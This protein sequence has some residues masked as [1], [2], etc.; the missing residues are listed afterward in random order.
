[1]DR[2][3]FHDVPVFLINLA[4]GGNSQAGHGTQEELHT[5]HGSRVQACPGQFCGPGS[6]RQRL[7][8]CR[9]D[10]QTVGQQPVSSQ[11]V[12]ELAQVEAT[13]TSN[14]HLEDKD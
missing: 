13:A 4:A 5:L 2:V 9:E 7:Q 11:S 8:V 14:K 12:V 10:G 1:V 3:L 6:L